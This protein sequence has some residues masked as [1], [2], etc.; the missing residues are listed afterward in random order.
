MILDSLTD[1]L[2]RRGVEAADVL[3]LVKGL[4]RRAK[5][6]GG[7]VYLILSEGV[8]APAVEQAVIDSVDGVL[9]FSWLTSPTHSHRERA[10]L[11]EKF[12]PVLSRLKSEYHGRFVI[13]VNSKN[14]L[15]TTQ[16]ERV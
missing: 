12:M 7:L 1:L 5:E 16:Y 9:H 3:T 6:W 14:G 11:I 13:R 10:M 8:A 4:R 2:V 15:V